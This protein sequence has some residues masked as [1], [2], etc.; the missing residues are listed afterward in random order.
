MPATTTSEVVLKL[1]ALFARFGCPDEIVS[2]N[3]RQFVSAEF[4][5]YAK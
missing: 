4:Q 3:V 1:N 2:D 5:E